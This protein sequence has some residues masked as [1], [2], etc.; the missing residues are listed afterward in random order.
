MPLRV[1]VLA[2]NPYFGGATSHILSIASVFRGNEEFE[3]CVGALPGWHEDNALVRAAE[4]MGVRVHLFPMAN[5][6]D[7]RVLGMFRRFLSDEQIDLVHTHGYR[8]TLISG[9]A[10]PEMPTIST[11]HGE[12]VVP[13][14]RTRLWERLSLRVMR[15]RDRRVIAC[16]SHVRDWLIEQGIPEERVVTIYNSSPAPEE[17][18][19]DMTRASLRIAPDALVFLYVGRLV[20]GKGLELLLDAA[21][22]MPCVVA[23]AGDGPLRGSLQERARALHLDV[24]FVGSV[25]NVT[26][27]YRVADAVVLPS[28]M[29]ALPMTLIEAA[30]HA[31]P[32]IATRVGGIPEVVTDGETGLL[33]NSGDAV[34]LREALCRLADPDLRASLGQAALQ[35][36]QERF[37]PERMAR[38][39]AA[40]YSEALAK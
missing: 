25:D 20:A 14:L 39:L 28:R 36:W 21:A 12:A 19:S 33:V 34:G 3:F 5:R 27:Y 7:A 11:C 17:P 8:G 16:S 10:A 24:R 31:K 40:V 29:E 2:D 13:A 22:A 9:L 15:K 18:A 6:V 23:L 1:L 35:V 37:T 30:A 32:V 38:E 26:P 4:R